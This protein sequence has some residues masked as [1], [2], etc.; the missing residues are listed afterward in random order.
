MF[1]FR[2][3]VKCSLFLFRMLVSKLSNAA[4]CFTNL[5]LIFEYL[6]QLSRIY[7]TFKRE[8]KL[9]I[10]MNEMMVNDVSCVR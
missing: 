4:Q 5:S 7:E 9:K 2:F 10:G 3:F 6:F 8:N 1:N